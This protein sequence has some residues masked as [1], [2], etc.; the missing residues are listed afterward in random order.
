MNESG[1]INKKGQSQLKSL[2]PLSESSSTAK[3]PKVG[4]QEREKC[5]AAVAE[6]LKDKL[7]LKA[8]ETTSCVTK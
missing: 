2:N 3:R 4:T 1:Y 5:I 8:A 7:Q 6:D